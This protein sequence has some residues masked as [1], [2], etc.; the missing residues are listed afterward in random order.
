MSHESDIAR[1]LEL[2]LCER[3]RVLVPAQRFVPAKGGSDAEDAEELLAPFTV[4]EA[5]RDGDKPFSD[6]E[7]YLMEV[8]V[9][10]V[11]Q[12]DEMP[13]SAHGSIL[14]N[15]QR[16]LSQIPRGFVASQQ[17]M[18]HGCDVQGPP[19]PIEPE[20]A[21]GHYDVFFLSVGCSG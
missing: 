4:V 1:K 6:E 2:A 20:D 21:K 8:S 14:G 7:T 9:C 5:G 17:L 16:A 12:P 13:P 11:T 18:I 15:I 3:L 19:R 10:L